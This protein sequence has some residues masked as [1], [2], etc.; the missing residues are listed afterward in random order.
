MCVRRRNRRCV[1]CARNNRGG[2][3]KE[4]SSVKIRQGRS[5]WSGLVVIA[6]CR[7]AADASCGW[8]GGRNRL[9]RHGAFRHG[10]TW[11]GPVQRSV[12]RGLYSEVRH[13]MARTVRSGAI[14]HARACSGRSRWDGVAELFGA[15]TVQDTEEDA[16]VSQGNRGIS[17]L[18]CGLGNRAVSEGRTEVASLSATCRL[19]RRAASHAAGRRGA[20][21][22]VTL[23]APR[24]RACAYPRGSCRPY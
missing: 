12:Q 23:Y 4:V 21:A 9:F 18:F 6:G 14:R 19:L 24:I 5:E 3:K 22:S 1:L 7:D 13:V 10:A 2:R 8:Y 20:L 17:Q 11:R 15:G 16:P